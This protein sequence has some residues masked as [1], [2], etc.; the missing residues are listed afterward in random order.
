MKANPASAAL[1][2]VGVGCLA[3]SAP[4]VGGEVYWPLALL[5]ALMGAALLTWAGAGAS[6]SGCYGG[7]IT[8]SVRSRPL[9][10]LLRILVFATAPLAGFGA[11]AYAAASLRET[12]LANGSVPAVDWRRAAGTGLLGL[13]VVLTASAA[14]LTYSPPV[15]LWSVLLTASG[16]ALFW[17][18][19]GN[20]AHAD[21]YANFD[22]ATVRAALGGLLACA[23]AALFAEHVLRLRDSGHVALASAAVIA[24]LVFVW[25][26]WA[27]RNRRLLER[28]RLQRALAVE[29]AELADQLHDSVLQTLALIQ[30]RADEPATVEGLARRQERELRDWLLGRSAG[31][32]GTRLEPALRALVAELEDSFGIRVDL[33]TVGDAPLDQRAA[34]L[35]AAAREALV[36]AARHAPGAPLAVFLSAGEDQLQIYV[37]DRGPGFDLGVIPA[38]RHGISDSIIAR[39]ERNGGRAEISSRFGEG[40]EITLT[41]QRQ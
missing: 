2:M 5:C 22:H 35:L 36:N 24:V 17:S 25:E 20:R 32:E 34:A 8:R 28:E 3:L 37:H 38:D 10:W 16:L 19:A 13:A 30:R 23:G 33:V 1:V 9:R 11:L 15:Y 39:M 41:M 4:G 40:C 12:V 14:H 26:P 7:V 27:L 18:A 6:E 21:A 29:R 31:R